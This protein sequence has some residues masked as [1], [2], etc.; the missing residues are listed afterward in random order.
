M[1]I[2]QKIAEYRK[3]IAAVLVPALVVLGAALADGVVSGQEWVA[4]V[5][6]ALGTGGAVAVISNRKPA[7]SGS[8]T[9]TVNNLTSDENG[10][11]TAIV[12]NRKPEGN[13]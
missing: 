13:E 4:I 3:A 9:A 7:G 11:A 8:A 12:N 1:T 2:S 10:G 6:A 5:V